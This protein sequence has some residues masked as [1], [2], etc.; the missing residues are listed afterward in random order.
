MLATYCGSPL[1]RWILQAHGKVGPE[2][3][4][5]R[6]IPAPWQCQ[7]WGLWGSGSIAKSGRDSCPRDHSCCS[8]L[9][10][11]RIA[12]NNFSHRTCVCSCTTARE[13]TWKVSLSGLSTRS[14]HRGPSRLT[15]PPFRFTVH[16]FAAFFRQ[17]RARWVCPYRQCKG[18]QG[19]RQRK[20]RSIFR[21][22]L[23]LP[24]LRIW[25]EV[26]CPG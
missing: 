22:F 26:L 19:Q 6:D 15:I 14:H 2:R 3:L 8:I 16:T 13:R 17:G 7:S 11:D 18:G 1:D 24:D 4:P 9:L 5:L 25:Q 21:I 20:Q 12:V 10:K 23:S